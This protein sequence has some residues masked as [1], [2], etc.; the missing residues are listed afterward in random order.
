MTPMDQLLLFL[1]LSI[2]AIS[3]TKVLVDEKTIQMAQ[4]M[5]HRMD[6]FWNASSTF[7]HASSLESFLPL[8]FPHSS[9]PLPF[10]HEPSD[11]DWRESTVLPVWLKDYFAWHTK[12]RQGLEN[13]SLHVDDYRF[14]VLRCIKKDGAC[15]GAA[16]RFKS[17][18]SALVFANETRRILLIKWDKPAPLETFLVPPHNGIDWRV[19]AWLDEKLGIDDL[20]ATSMR[21]RMDDMRTWTRQTICVK[22]LLGRGFEESQRPGHLSN[23]GIF[24]EMWASLFLPSPEVQQRIA[25]QMKVLGLTPNKYVSTHVRSR[26]VSNK[27]GLEVNALRCASALSPGSPMFFTSDSLNTTEAAIHYAKNNGVRLLTPNRTDEPIHLDRG[28][29]F[30]KNSN[31][32]NNHDLERFYD[33]FVDLYLLANSK[34][35]SFGSGG[36]GRLGALLSFNSSCIAYHRNTECPTWTKGPSN[37]VEKGRD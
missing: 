1:G 12:V 20:G 19:S 28:R 3:V 2:V 18:P 31:D 9:A 10:L 5:P 22:T 33:I 21:N 24:R 27:D 7:V 26:Y 30:L 17:L 32:W 36:Y 8:S 13:G 23:S 14:L 11:Y 34:C 6:D 4:D 35:V 37:S 16:D 29:D 25:D 15:S